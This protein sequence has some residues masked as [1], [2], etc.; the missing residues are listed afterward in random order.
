MTKEQAREFATRVRLGEPL[1]FSYT[2]S[3][4]RQLQPAYAT[5]GDGTKVAVE[6]DL[7]TNPS[8]PVRTFSMC[9]GVPDGPSVQLPLP[10]RRAPFSEPLHPDNCAAVLALLDQIANEP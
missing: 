10:Y 8:A 3:G 2:S 6:T 9:W 1:W 4:N 5:F 7:E